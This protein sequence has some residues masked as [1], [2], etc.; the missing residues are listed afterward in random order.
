MS[1]LAIIHGTGLENFP[2]MQGAKPQIV[3]T[4]YGEATVYRQQYQGQELVFVPRHDA[5][6]SLPPH[7]IN[8]RANIWAL[9]QLDI[10]EVIAFFCVGSLRQEFAPGTLVLVNQFIDQT[11]GRE[12]TFS[13]QGRVIHSE[14]TEPYCQRS[15]QMLLQAAQQAKIELQYPAT[16]ICTQG[17]RLETAAEIRAYQSWGADIVGMTAVPETPLAREA[18]LCY[19]GVAIVANYGAGMAGSIDLAA[20][21]QIM[22]QQNQRLEDLLA[23]YLALPAKEDVCAC[24]K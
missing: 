22:Q 14:Q 13:E 3:A 9:K 11:W 10:T 23:A 5:E 12:H 24:C 1:N 20:I 16:Y 7:L 4:P 8:Y 19:S 6:H 15:S 17:P 18:G 21:T 2:P